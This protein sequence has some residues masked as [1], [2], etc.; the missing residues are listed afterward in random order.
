MPSSVTETIA[1]RC[2]EKSFSEI[3]LPNFPEK[4]RGGVSFS[5]ISGT[6]HLM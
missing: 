3:C 1:Q 4:P 5:K 6:K 2:S